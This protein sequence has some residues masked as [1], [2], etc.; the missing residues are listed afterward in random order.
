MLRWREDKPVE[1]ADTLRDAAPALLPVD[2]H[3]ERACNGAAGRRRA[4]SPRAAGSRSRSSARSGRRSP[5]ARPACCTRPP[6]PAR[7]MR[8]GSA[9]CSAF[10]RPSRPRSARSVEA[11][12][13]RSTV[14]WLTPMRALAADT[15]RALQR[16]CAMLQPAWTRRRAHRRHQRRP[17]AR[18]EPAAADGAGH[19]AGEP[20]A[21]AVARRRAARCSAR[22]RMVVVD[23][24]HELIGNKRGVQ[25]QL[26]LARLRRWN[27]ALLRLG[28]VGH[29]RQPATQAMQTL[30]RPARQRRAGAGRGA[31]S[32]CVDR[33]AAA[34]PRR[35]LSVGRAPRPARCCRRWSRRSRPAAPR[36]SSPTRAR[37][38]RSGTRRCSKRGPTGPALIALHHGSLD[39][40]VR[41]WVEL[42][43]EGRRAE[44]GGLHLEP[45]SRR[46]LPAG[47][48][49]AADRLA[50]GR[51]A[52]AA[53]RRAARGHAP[54]RA[55]AHHA[56]ADAQP[57]AGR[58]ARPRATRVAARP[59]RG[60]AARRDKPL[61]VLVQHLV[62]VA[63]GGGFAP[64]A[65]FDEVRSACAYRDLTRDELAVVPR[66]RRQRRPVAHRLSRL[67][68]RRARRR[69]R[70]ARA[71]C[72]AG[73][74]P[75][76]EH[77]HHRQRR[78]H[79]GAVPAAA[80]KIGSVEESF[81]ARLKP[82]DCFLFGGRLLEL[83]RI[84]EM[85]AYVRRASGKKP[86]VPR[87]NGGRM[88]LSSELADARGASSSTLAA[89]GDF[90]RPE[91][92]RVR[93]LLEIQ[94]R[95][96]ALP[97]PGH[98]AGRSAED[99]RRLASVPLSVRRPPRAPGP[100]EP[101]RLARRRSTQPRTF[102]IA[103]N[104]YGFELLSA[105]PR[106]TGRRCCRRCWRRRA[107]TQPAARGAGIAQCERAGAAALSRDR[108]RVGPDLPGL[109][110]ARSAAQAVAGVV[111]AVLRGVPQVRPGQPAAAAGRG[112]SAGAGARD[113][114]PAREPGAH[115][116][117][118]ARAAG[119]RAADAVRL[120][121]DGRAVPREALER[122]RGR[123]D[124][125]HGG[126]AGEG[127]G[128]GG[129]GGGCAAGEGEPG[130]S[131]TPV[132][133]R[134]RG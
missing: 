45:R 53:A 97:T 24:W 43:A 16:R 90:D 117:A 125:A 112:G 124:R 82:G 26:A 119:A 81:V 71:R 70:L 63:L 122:E 39:R 113:R 111:L 61:D 80:R 68:P 126:A 42:G 107:E 28:P 130:A 89:Q 20:V 37:R 83:V 35:A 6:A 41:E 106:S 47:R 22:V 14:L 93:P 9:R 134:R 66:L 72:A 36:W 64:D 2:R 62:T 105:R 54:G 34:R 7:P 118:A 38:P 44:G 40:A 128:R 17:S 74:P 52:A 101:A 21:D 103:V 96:S 59:H 10:G 84:H 127:G 65:L 73:A 15:A 94:Q 108:A 88:P 18:A 60:A 51:R 129:G 32:S 110:R 86:A 69:R 1:E 92:Q 116:D 120:S 48:A 77:R 78:Q 8:S 104:D 100:G 57:R 49:R 75:P 12:R 11:L 123:P 85:T 55:V 23:E 98:A 19:H 99:A 131:G 3:D 91:L 25:V 102:S 46:R 33:H 76:H 133:K 56:G 95:W 30:L 121:A 87:W 13:R 29:A 79:G 67:P 27:P 5:K 50:Q 58:G 31:A 114:P 109:S 132:E 115:G 4:G